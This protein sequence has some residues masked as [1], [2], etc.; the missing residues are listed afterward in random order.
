MEDAHDFDRAFWR[1][2]V[3][4]EMASTTAAPS[5]VE[6]PKTR[7]DLVPGLGARNIGAVSKLAN[8]LNERVP[9]HPRLA[10]AKI[11]RGPFEDVRK[12][13]FRGSAETNAPSPLGHDGPIRLFW[14]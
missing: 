7:H 10:R 14:R 11:L 1:N 2:P 5:N 12:V 6:R 9:I 8:R 13:K 4:Q 3:H